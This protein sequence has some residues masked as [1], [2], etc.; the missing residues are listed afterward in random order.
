VEAV[1]TRCDVAHDDFEGKTINIEQARSWYLD[2]GF[3]SMGRPPKA[4]LVDDLGS[5]KGKTFYVGNRAFGKLCRVYEKGK[6]E[7]DP[8]SS[9]NRL[10][11]EFRSK[12]REIP[13][14]IVIR[15]GD[16]LAGAYPC[17]WYL[18]GCQERIRT[19][20]TTA[21]INYR[22]MVEWVRSAAGRALNVMLDVEGGDAA[23]VLTQVV[24][25]GAPK[26]LEAYSIRKGLLHSV[27][28]ADV[29]SP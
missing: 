4:K 2:G 9:W 27:A 3:G 20:R 1:I 22:G 24:R 29:E 12:G 18:S 16:Y 7:G 5:G 10:E 11:V 19:I 14:D 23:S 15:P 25:L 6:K 8:N 26:R 17:L 13:W 21:S 28:H